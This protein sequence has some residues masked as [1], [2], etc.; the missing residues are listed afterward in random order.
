[1]RNIGTALFLRRHVV[2][3]LAAAMAWCA[4]AG[5]SAAAGEAA[6]QHPGWPA[7]LRLVS[8]PAGGEWYVMAER[9][10]ELFSSSLLRTTNRPGGGFANVESVRTKNADMGFSLTCF[11][12]PAFQAEDSPQRIDARNVAVLAN[13]YPQVLYFILRKDFAD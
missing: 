9:M 4:L 11:L 12:G 7:H 10:A 2:W 1:M 13:L 5:P 3:I 8:G 6:R